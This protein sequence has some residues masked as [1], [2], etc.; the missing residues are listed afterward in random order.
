MATDL[1]RSVANQSLTKSNMF[2][3]TI[4]PEINDHQEHIVKLGPCR[5]KKNL[6]SIA[7][8]SLVGEYIKSEIF[9]SAQDVQ[10]LI[11]RIL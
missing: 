3:L 5:D 8:S 6:V 2:A 11:R 1:L 9:R 7:I 4:Y 10:G